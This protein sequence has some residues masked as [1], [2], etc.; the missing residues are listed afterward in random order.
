MVIY[1]LVRRVCTFFAAFSLAVDV[2]F[3]AT[4]NFIFFSLHNT[5]LYD[6][7][8]YSLMMMYLMFRLIA[9]HQNKQY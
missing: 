4:E 6:V 2:T 7:R 8:A 1:V 9:N 5:A 3:F